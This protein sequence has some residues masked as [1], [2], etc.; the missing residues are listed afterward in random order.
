MILGWG[1]QAAGVEKALTLD[2]VD[3]R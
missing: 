2:V 3:R 1:G